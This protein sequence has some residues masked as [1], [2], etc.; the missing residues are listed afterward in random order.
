MSDNGNRKKAY[1]ELKSKEY[2]EISVGMTK[3]FITVINDIVELK[4]LYSNLLGKTVEMI[5][6]INGLY[7]NDNEGKYH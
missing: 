1:A 3:Q 6:A 7:G 2:L 5:D 4:T